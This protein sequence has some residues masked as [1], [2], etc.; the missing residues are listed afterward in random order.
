MGLDQAT[1]AQQLGVS[2]S[3]LISAEHGKP[4]AAIGLVLRALGAVGVTIDAHASASG[5]PS[6]RRT[7]GI[8]IDAVVDRHRRR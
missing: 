7:H 4:T 8:D 2:R 1:L 3:W 5:T 6:R